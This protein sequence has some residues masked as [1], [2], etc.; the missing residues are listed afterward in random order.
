MYE[1]LACEC[2]DKRLG[3]ENRQLVANRIAQTV[4]TTQGTIQ[5]ARQ[6]VTDLVSPF[7]AGASLV[8]D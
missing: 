4:I 7:S 3:I 2:G 8:R 1:Y 6:L 5:K